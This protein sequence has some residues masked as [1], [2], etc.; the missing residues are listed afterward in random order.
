LE[1]TISENANAKSVGEGVLHGDL[2]RIT[3]DP[4]RQIYQ[5]G[6][7]ASLRS[8]VTERGLINIPAWGGGRARWVEG[9]L[10]KQKRV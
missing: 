7:I 5:D 9:N 2:L 4:H 1:E 10:G 8:V 6:M 3:I